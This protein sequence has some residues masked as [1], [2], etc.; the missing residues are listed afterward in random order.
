MN[1][2]FIQSIYSGGASRF[3][4][5]NTYVDN[6]R[7]QQPLFG[8]FTVGFERELMPTLSVGVDYVNIRGSG[9]LNRI[10]YV[11]PYRDGIDSSDELTWYDV[12][13]DRGGVYN[14]TDTVFYPSCPNAVGAGLLQ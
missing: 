14:R 10:N 11:A 7:R 6:Y 5:A 9:L 2:D 3:N 1:H 13:P 4:E 12:F 8:Q